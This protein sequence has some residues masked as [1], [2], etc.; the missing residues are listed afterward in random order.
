MA[1]KQ[2]C[3]LHLL[4]LY[5]CVQH[6]TFTD[7]PDGEEP[8]VKVQGHLQLEARKN[9]L[10]WKNKRDWVNPRN[11]NNNNN[12]IYLAAQSSPPLNANANVF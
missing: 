10:I 7:P 11:I 5:L 4:L 12:L 3:S 8:S 6:Y 2:L 1:Q 9:P